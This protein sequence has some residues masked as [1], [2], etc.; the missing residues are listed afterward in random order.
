MPSL[1]NLSEFVTKAYTIHGDKYE[2]SESLYTNSKIK[3]TIICKTHGSFLQTPNMHLKGRGCPL[4][5]PYTIRYNTKTFVERASIIH[6]QYDYSKVNYITNA[7]KVEIICNIHGPFWQ[8]V[9][10]HLYGSGC[11]KCSGKSI[12]KYEKQLLNFLKEFDLKCLTSYRPQWL[13]RKEL[14]IYIPELN[15]AIEFNGTAYHHSSLGVRNFLDKTVKDKNYH[16]DKYLICKSNNINLLHIFE[17]ENLDTWFEKLRMYIVEPT[18]YNI[19]F[20]NT[21][22]TIPATTGALDFYG[23]SNIFLKQGI[24]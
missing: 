4:C 20:E 21:C 14:D 9:N 23:I 13:N 1:S 3:I 8:D 19:N 6:P 24:V 5:S 22:R 16:L 2:Y 17:F 10:H 18:R 12:S 7:H 15:L 11:S